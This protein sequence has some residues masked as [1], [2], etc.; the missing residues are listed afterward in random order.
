MACVNGF[1][2]NQGCDNCSAKY[3][4]PCRGNASAWTDNPVVAGVTDIKAVHLNQMRSALDA[5]RSR[6]GQGSC[7]IGGWASVSV[8]TEI[9]AARMTDLKNCNN[10]LTYYP[11]DGD[12]LNLVSDTFSIGGL[13][14]ATHVNNMRA[15]IN[16]NEVRCTCNTDCGAD[17][18]FCACFGDC[19]ACNYP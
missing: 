6:R 11:L 2:T 18:C 10:G 13:V 4:A 8:G 1:C 17:D 9:T 16:A 14:F 12:S 5:E 15:D 7:G 19:G 3:T